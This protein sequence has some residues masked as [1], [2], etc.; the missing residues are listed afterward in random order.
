M[1]KIKGAFLSEQAPR[2]GLC[3]PAMKGTET[4]GAET[5]LFLG[6]TPKKS[7][8]FLASKLE[9]GADF[10]ASAI[11]AEPTFFGSTPKKSLF[12]A[13]KKS[14]E[15]GA[16]RKTKK[17]RNSHSGAFQSSLPGEKSRTRRP[18]RRSR[19]S[20]CGGL[21]RPFRACGR[22]RGGAWLG[23]LA[24]WLCSRGSILWRTG[25]SGFR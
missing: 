5:T 20:C 1:L 25:R 22:G 18:W 12:S 9:D 11:G 23:R 16:R 17:P 15:G 3:P 14:A 7:P 19:S 2:P 6:W 21:C 10:M 24:G 4:R 8:L 13:P